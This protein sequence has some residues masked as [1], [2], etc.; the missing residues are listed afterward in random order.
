MPHPLNLS[1]AELISRLSYTEDSFVERKSKSDRPGWLR[2]VVAFANS[3]PVGLP[4]I[5]FIGVDDAGQIAPD[6]DT[7]KTMQAFSDYVDAHAWPPIYKFPRTL[8]HAGKS[9][10][11]VLVP[12]SAERPHFAGRAF[13]R[14]GTQTKDASEAQFSELIAS[15][16]SKVRELLA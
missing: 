11:A 6:V 12:G 14:V 1:D 8:V 16:N 2:T 3:T 10:V 4:A 13:V 7:E 15:R 5:L 9:C